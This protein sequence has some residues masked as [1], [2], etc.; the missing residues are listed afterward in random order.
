MLRKKNIAKKEGY[1]C[2]QNIADYLR[3]V[4]DYCLLGQLRCIH[5]FSSIWILPP[6]NYC[7]DKTKFNIKYKI[8]KK[9]D[10]CWSI[11]KNKNIIKEYSIMTR[12]RFE[13]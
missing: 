5:S 9:N 8:N 6:D 11:L 7:K 2:A 4:L 3:I 13:I 12:N 10:T 1:S